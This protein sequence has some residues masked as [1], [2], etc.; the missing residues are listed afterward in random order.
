MQVTR[1]DNIS[2]DAPDALD[3]PDPP[4][5]LRDGIDAM[6]PAGARRGREFIIVD[7]WGPYDWKTPKLWPAGR[8][9][10][11]PL[12]LRVLGPPQ[13]WTLR[14]ITGATASAKAGG[15][16]GE[17]TITP[18]AGRVTDFSVTLRDDAGRDFSY[19]RFFAPIEWTLKFFDISASK[20]PALPDMAAVTKRPPIIE[21]RWDRIDYLS[22]RAIGLGLPN[23]HL[24]MTGE[25]VVELPSGEFTLRTISDD[26]VRVWV[27][28]KLTIDRWDVHE[29][30][31]DEV[32]I[33][34]GRHTLR[35]E[36]FERTGWAELRVEIVKR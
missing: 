9:D 16:P 26:G 14:S 13:K 18:A 20:E 23:D 32:Q 21:T 15:I 4:A 17:I 8:S 11:S 31:V 3:V 7:E 1:T 6:I 35:V 5:K 10:A 22:G 24:A 19:S 36:Y 25:G 34:G 30:V 29:S 28:G 2:L 33:S 12:Q 27:D